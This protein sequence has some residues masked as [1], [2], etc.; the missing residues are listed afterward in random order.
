MACRPH[1]LVRGHSPLVWGVLGDSLEVPFEAPFVAVVMAPR[2]EFSGSG[3]MEMLAG[4]IWG[5]AVVRPT[6]QVLELLPFKT[7]APSGEWL[8]A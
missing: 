3:G 6:M 5:A 2:V 8:A 7:Q 1:V 4:N